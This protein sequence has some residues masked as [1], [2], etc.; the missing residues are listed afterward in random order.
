M[1]AYLT[2][3]LNSQGASVSVLNG[4][5]A[6]LLSGSVLYA[7]YGGSPQAMLHGGTNVSVATIP[8]TQTCQPQ[9]PET[10]WWWN[11]SQDGRGFGI[12]VR[13]NTLFMSGYL[14]DD[15]GHAT[16]VVS[17][18]P[19]ALDGSLFNNTLYHVSNGQTLT[20]AYKA[21]APVT[22]DGPI[23]LSFTDA[24]TGTLIWPGGSIPIQRFDTIIG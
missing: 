20:G 9:A 3:V 18:G 11:P 22:L 7:G 19:V 24:R 10:G 5:S 21:P 13:G 15:T 6:A 1:Q 2:G 14:Y 12:E 16:W 17:A 8:S 4:V 23:T